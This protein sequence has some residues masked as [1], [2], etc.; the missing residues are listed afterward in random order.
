MDSDRVALIREILTGT[1]W[2][3]RSAEFGVAL[4]TAPR[5]SGRLLLVGTP[6][7]EPWH[8]AAHLDAEARLADLPQLVPTLVRHVV[9]PGAPS[10]LSVGLDRLADTRR[11]EALLVVAPD[12]PPEALLER[13]N[14]AR[15]RGATLLALHGGAPELAGLA[16]EMLDVPAL[17]AVDGADSLPASLVTF[18]TAQHLVSA[19]AGDTTPRGSGRSA[20]AGRGL[21]G[22][23][24]RMLD[25]VSGPAIDRW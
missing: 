6:A 2:L 15:H 5:G 19:A 18:D 21:R 12:E 13:L 23:L 10:H 3:G 8:M 22:R 14:D 17:T 24:G 9:E 1:P 20:R 4:R 11:G 7:E 16:H 25:A